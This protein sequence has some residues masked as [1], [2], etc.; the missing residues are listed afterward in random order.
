MVTVMLRLEGLVVALAALVAYAH[1][2]GGRWAAFVIFL[3]LPDLLSLVP[4]AVA[5]HRHAAGGAARWARLRP[6]RGRL[7]SS[8]VSGHPEIRRGGEGRLPPRGLFVLYNVVHA[9][10]TPLGLALLG[11]FGFGTLFWPLLG[12]VAHIGL[13]RTLGY[14]LKIYPYFRQTHLQ[15]EEPSTRGWW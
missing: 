14:G 10:F 3:V 12:W 1:A 4:F 7:E 5:E 6:R 13:D 8:R 2:G 15:V 9:Y 11:W